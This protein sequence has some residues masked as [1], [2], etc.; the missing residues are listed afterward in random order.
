LKRRLIKE[1]VTTIKMKKITDY[2]T[3]KY[4]SIY[5]FKLLKYFLEHKIARDSKGYAV[6]EIIFNIPPSQVLTRYALVRIECITDGAQQIDAEKGI[7]LL[8]EKGIL[9][10]DPETDIL[11]QKAPLDAITNV[12]LKETNDGF[13]VVEDMSMAD[14]ILLSTTKAK[15]P[16]GKKGHHRQLYI[17]G[18]PDI[19]IRNKKSNNTI[20]EI[21]LGN[22]Y[23]YT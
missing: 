18:V 16:S 3:Q 21:K 6:Y 14:V 20:V 4:G 22:P 23:E 13:E 7:E 19:L 2:I 17:A 11:E 10:C 8:I 15:V 12:N 9:T 5:A 1:S